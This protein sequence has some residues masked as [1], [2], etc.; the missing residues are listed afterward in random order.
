MIRTSQAHKL[1]DYESIERF[2]N[3]LVSR[4]DMTQALDLPAYEALLFVPFSFLEYRA[5]YIAFFAT[6]LALLGLSIRILRPFLEKLNE[7]W[8]WLPAAVFLC[9]LPV[10]MALI[11]GQD[12]IV[13]LTLAVA[14][15]VSFY[16]GRDVSAGV[17]LGVTLFRFQFAAP[18]ALLFLLWRKWRIAA[19][20][21]VTGVAVTTISLS[22]AGMRGVRAFSEALLSWVP[23]PFAG[24]A[25]SIG[26]FSSAMPNLRCLF[27][28]LAGSKISLGKAE[29]AAAGCSI[30]L[31][32]WAATRTPNFALAVLVALLVSTHGT[33]NDAVL[34]VIP[35]AMVLDARLTV[36]TGIS[37]LWSRNIA[38]MLFVGPSVCF[39]A[40]TDYCLLAPL[41]LGLLMPLRFTSADAS[42]LRP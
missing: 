36:S 24:E 19:G 22:L 8:R 34:L 26:M 38:S 16:R 41:M 35:I 29:V 10:A 7:V 20:F 2:Q 6:N 30:L 27:L 11:Q 21:S 5:A 4:G 13:L 15:A 3:D 39:L 12:S 9:F 14:S 25:L 28:A 42:F 23:Q 17:F 40:R 32:A 33:I 18:I 1:Y 31:L 37:R